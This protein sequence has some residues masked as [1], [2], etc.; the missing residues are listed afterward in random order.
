MEVQVPFI[1][2]ENS[3][4]PNPEE[5]E[6]PKE[7]QLNKSL[8]L[9]ETFL[10]V[11]GF[12]QYSFLSFTLSWVSFLLLGVFLPLLIIEISYC[13]SDCEK[14]QIKVFELE[15]LVS[16]S[17]GAAIS[18]LCV[19]HNLRKYGVR[20]FLFV[21]KC[22]GHMTQFREEY[23][24]KI[25]GFFRLLLVWVLPCF[26]LKAAREVLRIRYVD[27]DS[28]WQSAAIIF[29]LLFSWT[30]SS[31]IFLS[32]SCLFNL[33]CNLQIIHFENYGKLLERDLDVSAYIEEHVR[34]TH[35][36]SKI[37]HRFRIFL[38]LEFLIVTASQF[39]ALLQT[40][41]N[42]GII[43][44]INGGDFA[45]TSIVELVGIIIC[46]HAAAKI[47]HRAQALASVTS[48]WHALV[49]CNSSNLSQSNNGGNME[50]SF[51]SGSGS[52]PIN[53]SES[54]LEAV[55][56][57]PVPANTQLASY[58]SMYH[59]RQAFVTYTLSHRGGATIF[60]W[61]VDRALISTIFFVELSLVLFVLGKTITFSFTSST[62]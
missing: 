28:W 42:R 25:R 27:K 60:G 46:L 31:I 32:G 59:K 47:S 35:H 36:L 57:V 51:T 10:R 19:S 11:L 62:K 22:H 39:V 20:R 2:A 13:S 40:T 3:S 26:L 14:Y 9:L 6:E 17:L 37:S 34:L 18:L 52:M 61:T 53:Y 48:R 49:T 41:G 55:D 29:G 1:Q 23:T 45:V 30:F 24:K 21:D 5:E 50:A 58:M 12:C 38:L 8:H 33:V 16:Q 4:S 15:I 7:T 56:F 44:F 43:N 54:D